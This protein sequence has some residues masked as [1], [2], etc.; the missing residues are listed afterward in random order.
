M[1]LVLPRD[2]FDEKSRYAFL[3]IQKPK[4]KRRGRGRIQ[5]LRVEDSGAAI[6]LLDRIFG[7]LNDCLNSSSSLRSRWEKI[8]DFLQVPRHLRPQ[9]S[10]IFV[11]VELWWPTEKETI[12]KTSF[13][14]W[15]WSTLESYLQELAADSI[16]VR[17]P[18][19]SKA[20]IRFLASFF[21][22]AM[23]PGWLP[24]RYAR[25]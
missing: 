19:S 3:K 16:L 18:E 5:H 1:D 20:R 2:L 15:D 13:G 11:E 14:G 17:L 6:D 22:G 9:P 23:S 21:A 7:H 4:T 25:T 10:S 24:P 8:L 12:H